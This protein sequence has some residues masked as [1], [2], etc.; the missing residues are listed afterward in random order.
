LAALAR[1]DWPGNIRELRNVVERAIALCDGEAVG[2]ADLPLRLLGDP[3][4]DSQRPARECITLCE[5]RAEAE[6][7]HILAALVKNGNNRLRTAKELEI[8]RVGLY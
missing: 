6:R 8:S 5:S 1:H 2:L 4:C 3:T 7:L